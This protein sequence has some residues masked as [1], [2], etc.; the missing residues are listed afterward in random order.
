M[1][2][3]VIIPTFNEQDNIKKLLDFFMLAPNR[4]LIEIIVVDGGSSDDTI[5]IAQSFKEVNV[6]ISPKKGRA[7]QM[8]YGA[9]KAIGEIF[10]FVHADVI[11]VLNYYDDVI[12]AI[13]ENDFGCY[14]YVFDSPNNLLKFNA[15]MTRYNSVWAG[16]GDQ[17]L[18]I[19]KDTFFKLN[20]FKDELLIMEDFD[21]V[22]RAKKMKMKFII[23]PCN[24]MVSARKYKYN[25][26]I[27]VQ[28]ANTLIMLA[29]KFG[30]SQIW[31]QDKYKKLLSN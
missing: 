13:T 17:T 10:Y 19:K 18:F 7:A 25:S 15:Y 30:A 24:V 22:K 20:G 27:K 6:C 4:H 5:S 23:L 1:K 3:S 31:L 29:W 26:W 21:L 12:N 2:V 9:S 16:G 14:R 28:Y 8:N 11:P